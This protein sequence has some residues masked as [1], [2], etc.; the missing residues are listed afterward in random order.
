MLMSRHHR[1]LEGWEAPWLKLPAC[2]SPEHFA[3][4]FVSPWAFKVMNLLVMFRMS[5]ASEKQLS[6]EVERIE[7]TCLS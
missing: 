6:E 2:P 7:V 4:L 1:R 3:A 5:R